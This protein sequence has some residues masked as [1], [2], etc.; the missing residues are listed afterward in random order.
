MFVQEEENTNQ[1]NLP[2]RTRRSSVIWAPTPK[3][4][5]R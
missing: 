3:T 4:R 2:E 1:N 5:P